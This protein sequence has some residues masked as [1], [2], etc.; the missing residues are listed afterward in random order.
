[1]EKGFSVS[2]SEQ[3]EGRQE[4]DLHNAKVMDMFREIGVRTKEGVKKLLADPNFHKAMGGAL[5]VVGALTAA[6]GGAASSKEL[7]MV[8]MAMASAGGAEWSAGFIAGEIKE[9]REKST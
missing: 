6:G 4:V 7:F 3:R 1:M 5:A 8:G 9:G 2:K